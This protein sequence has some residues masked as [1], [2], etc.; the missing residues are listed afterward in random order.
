MA[1]PLPTLLLVLPLAVL[2]CDAGSAVPAGHPCPGVAIPPNAR[3]SW[4]ALPSS[5]EAVPITLLPPFDAGLEVVVS[6]GQDELPT[7]VG[8]MRWAWDFAVPDGTRVRAAAPGLVVWV[9]DDSTHASTDL[10]AAADANW[11]AIDHGGGL[12]TSY[13]HLGAGT[14]QVLPGDQVSAGDVLAETGAS[15]LMG[16]PHLHFHVENVWGE[17]VPAAF[18]EPEAPWD[19]DRAPVRAEW[20]RRPHDL[21]ELLVPGS[22]PSLLPADAFSDFGIAHVDPLPARVLSRTEVYEVG[23]VA[24]AGPADR[25]W[26]LVFP[27]GGGDSVLSLEMPLDHAGGFA[28]LLSLVDLPAG[29]YGWALVASQGTDAQADRAIRVYL[30]D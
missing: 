22:T 16:A 19:C 12:L 3:A 4:S 1:R 11:I 21:A 25:A 2:A 10:S 15:G 6:Q 24:A 5:S 8:V 7:H 26:V 20:L 13:V 23:G 17:T 14:A 28:G 30:T 9:R 27:D 29:R 18:V